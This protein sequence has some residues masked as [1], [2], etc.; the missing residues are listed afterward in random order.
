MLWTREED[1]KAV[2]GHGITTDAYPNERIR[3]EVTQ[4]V[5]VGPVP[6]KPLQFYH[7]LHCHLTYLLVGHHLNHSCKEE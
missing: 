4:F 7:L 2:R 6:F 3:T 5:V 1:E